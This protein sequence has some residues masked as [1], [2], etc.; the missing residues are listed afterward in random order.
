M[1]VV[2]LNFFFDALW[3]GIP[4]KMQIMTKIK[5][6]LPLPSDHHPLKFKR[7][8]IPWDTFGSIKSLMHVADI[9]Q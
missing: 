7:E 1:G 5:S 4:A 3:G 6:A 2:L 9:F 8:G